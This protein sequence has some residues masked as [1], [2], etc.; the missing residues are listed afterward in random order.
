[1]SPM[2]SNAALMTRSLQMRNSLLTAATAAGAAGAAG[3]PASGGQPSPSTASALL[4]SQAAAAAMFNHQQASAASLFAAANIKSNSA[5]SGVAG[6]HQ[7]S[8]LQSNGLAAASQGEAEVISRGQ[9][10][11]ATTYLN[12]NLAVPQSQSGHS[13]AAADPQQI[14]FSLPITSTY[15]RRMR[16]LGLAAATQQGFTANTVVSQ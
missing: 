1:M 9:K 15:L 2:N 8:I 10:F 13:I 4:A 6:V 16:A 12:Q 3:Q 7:I 5:A 14:D 11:L